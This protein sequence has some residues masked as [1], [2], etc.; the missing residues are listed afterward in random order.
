MNG[1]TYIKKNEILKVSEGSLFKEMTT[2]CWL[3]DTFFFQGHRSVESASMLLVNLDTL[4]G[5]HYFL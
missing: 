2:I 3:E 1:A 5:G 4:G